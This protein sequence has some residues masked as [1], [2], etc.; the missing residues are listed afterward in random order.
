M[1]MASNT[2]SIDGSD[3]AIGGRK[4]SIADIVAIASTASGIAITFRDGTIDLADGCVTD[5]FTIR[6][7]CPWAMAAI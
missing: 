4:R 1:H 6:D 2:L 3:I 7:R 5:F